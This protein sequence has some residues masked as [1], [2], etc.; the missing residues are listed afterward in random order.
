MSYLYSVL[1]EL[2]PTSTFTLPATMGHL[3]H[4][5]FLDLIRQVDPPLSAR[6]HDEPNYRPFT[7]SPLNGVKVQNDTLFIKP[8]QLCTLRVTLLD[9]GTLWQNLSRCFLEV[10]PTTLR[11]GNAEFKLNRMLSTPTADPGGWAGFTDWQTLATTPARPII[12]MRFASPTAFSLGDRQFALFPE[13]IY[14]WDSLMRV[15]NNYAPPVLR[16]DKPA[17][18]AFISQHVVI[19]DYALHTSKLRFPTHGQKGFTGTCSYLIQQ[20]KEEHAAT[21]AA[22]AEFARYAGVGSKTTMGMGQART[23]TIQQKDE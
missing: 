2:S 13:P 19:H 11:L 9:G 23:E 8:N 4:A 1:L 12:T 3:A 17:L 14:L 21:L 15:W 22:L 7:V 5:L 18:R 16:I 6:L 10:Q 20:H